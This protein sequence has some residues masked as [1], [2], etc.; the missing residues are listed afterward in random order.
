MLEASCILA[1]CQNQNRPMAPRLLLLEFSGCV[2][3]HTGFPMSGFEVGDVLDYLLE[4]F[5][6]QGS[7]LLLCLHYQLICLAFVLLTVGG[8]F[9]NRAMERQLWEL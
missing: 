7:I 9:Q 6:Q 2:Y 3:A 1:I 5:V 4:A 8:T